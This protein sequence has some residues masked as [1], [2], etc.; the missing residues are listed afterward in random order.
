MNIRAPLAPRRPEAFPDWRFEHI[1]VEYDAQTRSVWMNYKADSPHCYTRRMLQNAIDFRESLR[2]L[3]RS[4]RAADWPLRY[5]VMASNKEAVFSLGGDLAA[6]AASIRNGDRNALMEYAYA[7]ID[8]MYGVSSAFD[9]PLVTLAAVRGQCMGGGFE[10]AL[11]TDFLIAE[12]GARLGVPEVAF[13]TFPG[14]GAVSFLARRVGAARAED[15]ISR[16]SVFSPRELHAMDLVDVIAPDGLLRETA[17]AWMREGGE[18]RWRRRLA[19]TR[20]RK[21]CFPLTRDELT[22]IVEIWTDCAFEISERDLRHMERLVSAQ[23][24]LS[25]TRATPAPARTME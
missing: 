18:E 3:L 22:R 1:D 4:D 24:R 15:I 8:V 13:N 9:L 11:A 17:R 2:A 19:L 21:R 6:F 16:G 20:H 25:G 5:F 23:R 14:M 7:C 10:G 12:E